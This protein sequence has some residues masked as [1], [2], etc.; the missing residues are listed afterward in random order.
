VRLPQEMLCDALPYIDMLT[1]MDHSC[2]DV[3]DSIVNLKTIEALVT[4]T[5][6]SLFCAPADIDSAYLWVEVAEIGWW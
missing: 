2:T 4:N 6:K 3:P 1:R 5:T